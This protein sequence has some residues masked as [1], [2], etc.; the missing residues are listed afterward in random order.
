M[1]SEVIYQCE[2][3]YGI[4]AFANESAPLPLVCKNCPALPSAP[5]NLKVRFAAGLLSGVVRERLLPPECTN[6]ILLKVTPPLK[7]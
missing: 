7:S 6:F 2:N 1:K 4:A 5:G 3:E